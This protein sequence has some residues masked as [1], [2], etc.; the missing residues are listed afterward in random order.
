M[1][2]LFSMV[3]A[4]MATATLSAQTLQ[5]SKSSDNIYI[6]LNGGLVMHG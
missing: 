4:L 3:V 1:K 6:G 2:K 5:E